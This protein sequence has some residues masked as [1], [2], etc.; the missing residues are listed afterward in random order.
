MCMPKTVDRDMLESCCFNSFIKPFSGSIHRAEMVAIACE[1]QLTSIV[2][3]EPH[4]QKSLT[5][6][7]FPL[8]EVSH[9]TVI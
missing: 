2:S 5:L 8:P 4:P 3:I 1:Y 7:T 6:N 9:G